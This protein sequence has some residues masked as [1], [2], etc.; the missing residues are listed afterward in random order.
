[1]RN[2]F[3]IH[4]S[5][6]FAA[7]F[8][9]FVASIVSIALFYA[10]EGSDTVDS[11]TSWSCRWQSLSMLQTPHW[12]TLCRQSYAGLYLSIVL[13]PVEAVVLALAGWEMKVERQVSGF[14]RAQGKRSP[15][16]GDS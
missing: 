7:P 5:V 9:G 10:I 1:L 16:A 14:S 8:C 13:I 12:N 3:P 2:T 6:T 15:V 11:L 4:T